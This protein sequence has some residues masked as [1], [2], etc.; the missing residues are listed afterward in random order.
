MPAVTVIVSSP[1]GRATR[2]GTPNEAR[3]VSHAAADGAG[4]GPASEGAADAA[5]PD[6]DGDALGLDPAELDV[7][8]AGRGDGD[9]GTNAIDGGFVVVGEGDGVRVA[10]VNIE[11]PV[12]A[13]VDLEGE[14][15]RAGGPRPSPR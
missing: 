3:P 11:E 7:G 6:D 13:A 5:L 10:N 12:L 14:A 8:A 4:P 1:P 2:I 9:G 15:R